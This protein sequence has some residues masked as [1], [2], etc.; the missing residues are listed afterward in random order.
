MPTNRNSPRKSPFSGGVVALQ[1]TFR[2]D[3]DE[4]IKIDVQSIRLLLLIGEDN[5]QELSPLTAEDVAD[6]VLLYQ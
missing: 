4:S 5:R 3:S 2:N 6:T 1:M